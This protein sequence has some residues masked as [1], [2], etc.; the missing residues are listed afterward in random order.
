MMIADSNLIIYAASGNYPALLEWFLD[1][2]LGASA[3]SLVEALAYHKLKP[4][5]KTALET[6]FSELT[7]YYPT[8][9]I[10]QTAVE[11]RQ[12]R[13]M[14]LGDALIAATAIYHGLT[15]ATHNTQDFERIK[16]LKV[17]DP[18]QA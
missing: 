16:A 15:L 17:L 7:I 6:I 9:E 12:G 14:W 11:L 3:V 18:L 8:P 13:A 10:F 2:K 1:N 5:E 4:R